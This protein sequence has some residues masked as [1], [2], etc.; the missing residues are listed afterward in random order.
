[1]GGSRWPSRWV[2][3]GTATLAYQ[4]ID[5]LS[6][7]L[8]YRHDGAASDLYFGGDVTTDPMTDAYV[9]NRQHLDTVTLVLTAIAATT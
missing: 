3:E 8:E 7:R 1:M 2:A 5:K 6:L 9:P 4:P